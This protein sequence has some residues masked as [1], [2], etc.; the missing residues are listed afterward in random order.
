MKRESFRGTAHHV[1]AP[2]ARLRRLIRQAEQL[3]N[4]DS[5]LRA[6]LPSPLKHHCQLANLKGDTAIIQTES[7]VWANRLRFQTALLLVHL[8][9]ISKRKLTRVKITVCP[10]EY[11]PHREPRPPLRVSEH[12]A[13]VLA[14]AAIGIK[15]PDLRAALR[16][17]ARH[18]NRKPPA[19]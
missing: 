11:P 7:P 15:D 19:A 4:L 8:R 16:R 9:D 14:A 2:S 10:T 5:E 1:K 12:S 17:L 6:R 18:V 3:Q 13:D